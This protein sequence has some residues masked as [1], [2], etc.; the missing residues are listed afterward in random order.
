M[1]SV[2]I[3]YKC[4]RILKGREF[5]MADP[6]PPLSAT[7][8]RD[9]H[10]NGFTSVPGFLT[11]EET[12]ILKKVYDEWI[13]TERLDTKQN[14]QD[15]ETEVPELRELDF[16][17]RGLEL[18]RQLLGEE[19]HL[20]NELFIYRP[21]GNERGTPWH[22][23]FAFAKPNVLGNALNLWIPLQDTGV[24]GGCLWFIPR[25]HRQDIIP[26]Y[27]Q[28]DISPSHQKAVNLSAD[29]TLFDEEQAVPVPLK[30]G[31]ASLHHCYTLHKAGP[32]RTDDTRRAFFLTYNGVSEERWLKNDHEYWPWIQERRDRE[33]Q[34]QDSSKK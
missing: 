1:R 7:Q 16:R 3:S 10:L 23:D 17:E 12:R 11:P 15:L 8:V 34:E 20:R 28:W 19:A 21:A 22:Q 14:L 5:D 30:A 32:N 29:T 27:N 2:T 9:F 24:D 13:L 18:A 33:N 6:T 4:T 26:H 31:D 25:S